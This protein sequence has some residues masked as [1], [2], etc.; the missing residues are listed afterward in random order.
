M[1]PDGLTPVGEQ[2]ATFLV[3][4]VGRKWLFGDAAADHPLE[5]VLGGVGEGSLAFGEHPYHIV[6][7]A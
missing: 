5:V 1:T 2:G 7:T 4:A 6:G 3:T